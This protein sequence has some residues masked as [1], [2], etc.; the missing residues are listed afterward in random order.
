MFVGSKIK[1]INEHV[2][3]SYQHLL[4]GAGIKH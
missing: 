4:R 3:K 2:D 1:L